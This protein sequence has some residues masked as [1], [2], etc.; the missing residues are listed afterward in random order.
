MRQFVQIDTNGT[1]INQGD[2]TMILAVLPRAGLPT[3]ADA[4]EGWDLST[5]PFEGQIYSFE[6]MVDTAPPT[7]NA[8]TQAAP[9]L[10]TPLLVSGTWTQQWNSPVALTADQLAA[11]V[12]QTIT[13]AQAEIALANAGL[14]AT[15]QEVVAASPQIDQIAFAAWDNWNRQSPMLNTLA[16]AAGISSAQLDALFTAGAGIVL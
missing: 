15:V 4:Y 7:Y 3:H 11:L 8:A 10:A 6:T 9:T 2:Y 16:T 5:Y 13:R 1:P 14:L 12:P